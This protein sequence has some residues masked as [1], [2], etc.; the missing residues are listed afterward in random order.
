MWKQSWHEALDLTASI[1]EMLVSKIRCLKEQELR[2][3][4][5][6]VQMQWLDKLVGWGL[7]E[8]TSS[9]YKTE[10]KVAV[11][12]LLLQVAWEYIII[13]ANTG[14]LQDLGS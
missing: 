9:Y 11:S 12:V 10:T 5:M 8:G 4:N 7:F 6:A 13:F 2:G 14:G 1:H 3:G